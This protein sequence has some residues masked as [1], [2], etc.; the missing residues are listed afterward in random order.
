MDVHVMNTD[1]VTSVTSVTGVH[2]DCAFTDAPCITTNITGVTTDITCVT[3]NVTGVT[4]NVPD[5]TTSIADVS[6]NI[7]DVTTNIT[8]VTRTK[9]TTVLNIMERNDNEASLNVSDVT[10]NSTSCSRVERQSECPENTHSTTE[11]SQGHSHCQVIEVKGYSNEIADEN[12]S[13]CSSLPNA[14]SSPLSKNCSCNCHNSQLQ[15]TADQPNHL[16]AHNVQLNT[17]PSQS[18]SS[19]QNTSQSNAC[20]SINANQSNSSLQGT[21]QSNSSTIEIGVDN[22]SFDIIREGSTVSRNSVKPPTYLSLCEFYLNDEPPKY[23]AITG[24]K[25]ADELVRLLLL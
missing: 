23:E 2:E 19:V 1:S 17:S 6:S 4:T 24:K 9:T 11:H 25:L 22:A 7:T 15:L 16:L 13:G 3:N 12:E 8:S 18:N 14:D 21:S 20:L 10:S 5:V